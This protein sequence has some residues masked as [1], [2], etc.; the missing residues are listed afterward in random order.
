MA[1]LRAMTMSHVIGRASCGSNE[2]AR[3]QTVTNV[4]CNTSSAS[5]LSLRIRRQTPKSFADVRE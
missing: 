3:R 2:P 5:P 1:R 4:S